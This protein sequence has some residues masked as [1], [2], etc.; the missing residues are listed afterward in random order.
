MQII[1]MEKKIEAGARF[2]QIRVR[3]AAVGLLFRL[4]ENISKRDPAFLLTLRGLYQ[5]NVLK[6]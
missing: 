2:L 1:K 3:I 6:W 5:K 4:N